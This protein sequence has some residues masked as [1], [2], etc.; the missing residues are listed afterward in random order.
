MDI[1]LITYLSKN[2][3]L[4]SIVLFCFFL[5][6]IVWI[7][8]LEIRLRKLTKGSNGE[9]LENSI[10]GIM[11]N[12]VSIQNAQKETLSKI[13]ELDTRLTGA[14][15]GVGLV[16]FNPFA[17]SGNSKPSFALALIDELGSGIV[18]STLSIRDSITMFSKQ[19]TNF[20]PES[21]ITNE[22]QLALDKARN[23]LHNVN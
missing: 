13:T 19:I 3:A 18:V 14:I 5:F 6:T 17:G 22:E 9:N 8:I 20:K 15:Q 7:V 16:R 21:E 23:S 2:S 4:A 11:K 10:A 1:N 12:Y